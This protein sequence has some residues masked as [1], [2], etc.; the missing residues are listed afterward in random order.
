MSKPDSSIKN[1]KDRIDLTGQQI[2]HWTVIN[3]APTRERW[4]RYWLCVCVCGTIKEVSLGHLRS[5]TPNTSCGCRQNTTRTHGMTGTSIWNR[6]YSMIQRCTDPN[7]KHYADWGGRGIT[8]CKRWLKFENFY[9]DMGDIPFDGAEVERRD[10]HA[11]YC[12][13]NCYW[14][15]RTQQQRNKRSN[16]LIEFKDQTKT[17][18]EWSEITG[19]K[20][21]T[22]SQRL[23]HGWSV[24]K[25][26]TA[27]L[28]HSV[29]SEPKK[30]PRARQVT[31]AD[32]TKTLTEWAKI[33]GIS[34]SALRYRLAANWPDDK[35]FKEPW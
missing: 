27:P 26:L 29:P 9:A 6:W 31:I 34:T 11:G 33:I 16:K 1:S 10:N 22:I 35:I 30:N 15:T 32:E 28:M 7:W 19:I 14:A 13:E 8:V 21:T 18:A 2:G 20:R 25:A 3:E 4:A 5:G 24:E 12:L 17:L 23:E